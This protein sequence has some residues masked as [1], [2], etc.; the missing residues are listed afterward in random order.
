M[1][2]IPDCIEESG[3]RY[4]EKTAL[5]IKRKRGE[6]YEKV[7]Y[8]DL[9]EKV[10]LIS[11]GLLSLGME[12]G[13]RVGVI[14]ENR[15]E[16][17]MAYLGILKGGGVVVPLDPQLK[18]GE[19][20][21]ILETAK[22]KFCFSSSLFLLNIQEITKSLPSFQKLIS[23]EEEA[24]V[25]VL[26]SSITE[27]EILSLSQLTRPPSP[28]K[29][30][31]DEKDLAVLIFTSGTTGKSKGVM[32][33]HRNIVSN[34]KAL[35][36]AIYF[37][38][39]DTFISLLPLHHVFEATCGFL[40]PLSKGAT[41]TY[42]QS[43]KSR[44]IMEGISETGV[45]VMLGVPLLFEKMLEGLF[46]AVQEKPPLTRGLFRTLWGITRGMKGLLGLNTGKR[47]FKS[48]RKKAGLTSIR[49][50][51]CAGAPLSP[52]VGKGFETLGISF[53]QG[54]GL[55]ESSPALTL[56]PEKKGKMASIGKALPGV[57]V[58]IANPDEKGVGEIIARGPNIMEGYY[59]DPDKSKEV[60]REGWLYT[61]DLGWQD[62]DGYFYI[63]GR[64]KNV[65]VT[66]AGKNV[67]PEEV[68]EELLRSPYI[69]EVM[70]YGK[71]NPETKREEVHAIIYPNYEELEKGNTKDEE[72]IR[73]IDAEIKKHCDKLADFK[74]VKDF[75]IRKEE[76]P[77]TSTRKIK[78]FM[79]QKR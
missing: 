76:F 72:V 61:G 67:Y 48:L 18:P 54:Y 74:R 43:L 24:P 37:D 16:W 51:F 47:L 28:V 79:I 15:P 62:R 34:V 64:S 22:V 68:E 42:A 3:G 75:E 11:G 30:P 31:V 12:K 10:D 38:E 40:V 73:I 55:S 2:I 69:A 63:A 41:I 46:R 77:K 6:A 33:S 5:Q 19:L 8:R 1:N 13:D 57:E 36:E 29:T 32:L 7:S 44:E 66:K 60:L 49:L 50:M 53:I 20:Q 17:A 78:R 9:R 71:S 26:S 52:E 14:S 35:Q 4:Q 65:I 59:E 70:V 23:L 25:G 27:A 56:N 45:T 21:S 58:K 39:K